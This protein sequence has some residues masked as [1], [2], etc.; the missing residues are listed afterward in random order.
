MKEAGTPSDTGA[1]NVDN[2]VVKLLT[3]E[4]GVETNTTPAKNP[5]EQK[6]A[7]RKPQPMGKA[8]RQEIEQ[9]V[10]CDHPVIIEDLMKAAPARL[11]SLDWKTAEILKDLVGAVRCIRTIS[12]FKVVV[13]CDSSLQQSRL[14]KIKKK[15][16][17]RPG[18]SK[19]HH[20]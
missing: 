1:S 6:G 8:R 17:D 4:K 11:W 10:F 19:V 18:G 5:F 12:R 7:T 13:G 14:T 16:E 20:T 2:E 15:D 3:S 9:P